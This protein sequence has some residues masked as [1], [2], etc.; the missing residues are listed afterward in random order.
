M[1]SRKQLYLRSRGAACGIIGKIDKINKAFNPAA[2]FHPKNI[3]NRAV[4]KVGSIIAH[5]IKSLTPAKVRKPRIKKPKAP[6]G[7]ATSQGASLG[8]SCSRRARYEASCSKEMGI[9]DAIR[10]GVN[11][12]ISGKL[13]NHPFLQGVHDAL[14]KKKDTSAEKAESHRKRAETLHG[15]GA[16]DLAKQHEELARKYD[17]DSSGKFASMHY[18]PAKGRRSRK[19]SYVMSLCSSGRASRRQ[20]Y[21]MAL[22]K[23]SKVP[24]LLKRPPSIPKPPS[25]HLPAAHTALATH[26]TKMATHHAAT[27]NAALAKA[28][29]A[30]ARQHTAAATAVPKAPKAP[31][32][33]VNHQ[34]ESQKHADIA[35]HHASQSSSAG[36]EHDRMAK[37]HTGLA[38]AHSRIGVEAGTPS[39]GIGE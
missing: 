10:E 5:P 11:T 19:A 7:V 22:S 23:P 8:T 20:Q 4:R 25:P 28:H 30:M 9:G 24:R 2:I 17:R 32:A 39:T 21:E 3:I 33:P 12:V 37:A 18:G 13:V 34:V 26:H 6:D 36:D 14:F 29:S 31:A 1:P 16:H 15:I 35:A 27:G 38:V